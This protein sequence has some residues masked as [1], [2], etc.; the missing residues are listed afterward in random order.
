[1]LVLE[2]APAYNL[3][4]RLEVLVM[5]D[6]VTSQIML[7]CLFNLLYILHIIFKYSNLVQSI[8]S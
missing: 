7:V 8:A 1:M 5:C 2:A 4:G 6:I 3:C